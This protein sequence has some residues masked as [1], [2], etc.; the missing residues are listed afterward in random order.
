MKTKLLIL[1]VLAVVVVLFLCLSCEKDNQLVGT[2]WQTEFDNSKLFF[3]DNSSGTYYWLEEGEYDPYKFSYSLK[4]ND[5][6]VNV[7]F[8]GCQRLVSIGRIPDL[9]KSFDFLVV[10][11][12][13]RYG[14]VN[15]G[16]IAP[17][18][19][20]FGILARRLFNPSIWLAISVHRSWG[21]VPFVID[22]HC[23]KYARQAAN[24][25]IAGS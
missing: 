2:T 11:Q 22:L 23:K 5:I 4:G 6:V 15:L 1:R 17:I 16:C 18:R 9:C 25:G 3:K 12:K 21:F 8:L 14:L 20:L 24:Y 7:V 13:K 19:N 10:K